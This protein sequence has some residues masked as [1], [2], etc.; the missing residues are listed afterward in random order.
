VSFCRPVNTNNECNLRDQRTNQMTDWLAGNSI[1]FGPSNLQFT[2][3]NDRQGNQKGSDQQSQ[4]H[5]WKILLIYTNSAVKLQ[6][7][8]HKSLPVMLLRILTKK[9]CVCYSWLIK[10]KDG[11]L[12]LRPVTIQSTN[13]SINF[14]SFVRE[15]YSTCINMVSLSNWQKLFG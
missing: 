9:H 1:G 12:K 4:F 13:W 15:H 5:R 3:R 11:S 14:D 6:L 8:T 10:V 2:G 7:T